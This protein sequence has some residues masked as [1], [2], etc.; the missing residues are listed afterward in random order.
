MNTALLRVTAVLW[1]AWGLLHL[2]MAFP[3][4]LGVRAGVEGLPATVTM[5]IGGE[6]A[7]LHVQQTL[8]EHGFNNGWFGLVVTIGSVFVWRG[9]RDAV[10]LCSIV[11]GLAHLGFTVFLVLPGHANAMGVAMT[12]VAASAVALGLL[13]ARRVDA[14]H[15][16]R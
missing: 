10:Y 16:D 1:G 6:H 14:Q 9:R 5:D 3:F 13:A 11:G 15:L 12:V 7:P 4:V 2:L 8:M